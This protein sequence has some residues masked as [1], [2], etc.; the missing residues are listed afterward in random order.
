MEKNKQSGVAIGLITRGSVSIKW[1]QH[2]NKI[3][4]MLP[5]GLMWE[6]IVVEDETGWAENR[7]KVVKKAQERGYEWLFFVDDD[8][9][10]PE[11]VLQRMFAHEKDIVSGIYWTKSENSVPVIFEK[12]GAGPMFKFPVDD[13]FEVDGSGL[14]CALINMKVFDDFDKAGI[15]YFKENWVME[16]DNGNKIKCPIG[17]DHYFYHHAKKFG[18]EVWADSGVLCDHYDTKSKIFYPSPETVREL[19]GEKLMEEGREDIIEK[20]NKQLGLDNEKKTISFVNFTANHFCGNE[21]EKRPLGGAETDVIH[22]AKRF[23]N[24][25]DF[26]VHVF[27]NCPEPGIYDN[28]IYHDVVK[29]INALKALNSDLLISSRNTDIFNRVNFKKDFNAKKVALWTHDM[30]GDPVYRNFEN[31]Y[32]HLDY[33]FA[34]TEFHKNAILEY[35]PF[36][37]ENKIFVARNGVHVPDFEDCDKVERVKGRMIYS[38]TPFRGLEILAEVFSEIRKRVPHATLRVYSSMKVYGDMYNDDEFGELYHTLKNTEGVEYMGSVKQSELHSEMCKAELLAY[39]NKFAETFCITAAEAATAGMPIVTSDYAALKEVV[40]DDIG[41]KIKG[42]PHSREY[43]A[44][45]V[46]AIVELLT[47]QEK[48]TQMHDSCL[49]KDFSWN[50][51]A[52]TWMEAF[53][54]EQAKSHNGE[55]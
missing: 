27:C 17:E 48:W 6:F 45:F 23:A 43:K 51:V 50:S 53:F 5:I 39:P 47:N 10:V 22:L 30:V 16:L 8:V 14:G 54:P 20:H 1:M 44:K 33:V 7:N 29:D 3:L 36:V 42:N 4:R 15:P 12:M 40:T 32:P 31:A 25:Y 11:D 52:D 34:L 55:L 37:E 38:S 26:N 28:V 35:Y 24:N 9:F 2:M 18:H 21:L 19:T 46:D 13:F 49:T 41:I